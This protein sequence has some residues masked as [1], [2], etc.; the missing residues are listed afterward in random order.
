MKNEY[1]R[2]V[3]TL[4]KNVESTLI[5]WIVYDLGALGVAQK[6]QGMGSF[7]DDK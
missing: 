3:R 4:M 1:Y 2:R 6:I 7:Q 5:T